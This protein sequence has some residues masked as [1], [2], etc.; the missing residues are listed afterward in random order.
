MSFGDLEYQE[1][2]S[3]F[4]TR[5]LKSMKQEQIILDAVAN[6][7]DDVEEYPDSRLVQSTIGTKD[8]LGASVRTI[9]ANYTLP[10]EPSYKTRVWLW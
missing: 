3:H 4:L 9:T 2:S 1:T 5:L 6:P 10:A 7:I 8:D